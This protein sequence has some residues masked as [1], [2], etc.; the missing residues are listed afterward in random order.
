MSRFEELLAVQDLD[1]TIDQLRHR[2]AHL[3]E[4][5]ELQQVESQR[6]AL[7]TELTQAIAAR[8]EVAARQ[9][10]FEKDIAASEGRIAE[11]E[12]YDCY[13]P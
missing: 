9:A 13:E 6:S 11:I 12:T 10:G 1:L 2:R 7:A 5:G 4:R 3:P 8:D